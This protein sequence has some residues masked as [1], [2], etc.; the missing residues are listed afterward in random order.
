M[1]LSRSSRRPLWPMR[2]GRRGGGA[3]DWMEAAQEASNLPPDYLTR[4][5]AHSGRFQGI[6]DLL[7]SPL[8]PHHACG[9]RLRCFYSGAN[10]RAQQHHDH[11]AV[12]PPTGRCH[13]KSLRKFRRWAQNWAQSRIAR[14]RKSGQVAAHALQITN[15]KLLMAVGAVPREPLSGPNSRYQGNLQ[16]LIAT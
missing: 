4:Q 1:R 12:L 5:C 16:G 8:R 6:R 14:K 10:C 15:S 11:S 9:E 3:G 13:R 2:H 7:P